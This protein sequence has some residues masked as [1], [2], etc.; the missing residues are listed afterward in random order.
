MQELTV[1]KAMF[2]L[3]KTGKWFGPP[4]IIYYADGGPPKGTPENWTRE[5]VVDGLTRLLAA[6]K[7]NLTMVANT[8]RVIVDD[9]HSR[10]VVCELILRGHYDRAFELLPECWSHS[11]LDIQAF[12]GY[13]MG[14]ALQ[15]FATRKRVHPKP[16]QERRRDYE[17]LIQKLRSMFEAFDEGELDLNLDDIRKA[18]N[19]A[20]TTQL[21]TNRTGSCESEQSTDSAT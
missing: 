8:S 6:T 5:T 10:F 16:P 3:D 14:E 19:D 18:I 7:L 17:R 9:K 11:A 12:T 1:E 20:P 21:Q 13:P 2:I 15:C 4:P